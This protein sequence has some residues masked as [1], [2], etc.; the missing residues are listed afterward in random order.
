[1]AQLFGPEK[2]YILGHLFIQGNTIIIKASS[3]CAADPNCI[4]LLTNAKV[5][6]TALGTLAGGIFSGTTLI[7]RSLSNRMGIG[8][9]K[10]N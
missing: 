9:L 7:L 5:L 10:D 6:G 2:L 4:N 3:E 8:Y 1:L